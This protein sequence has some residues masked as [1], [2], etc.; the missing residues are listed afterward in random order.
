MPTEFTEKVFALVDAGDA[1]GF[2]RLFASQ[3]WIR[4]ANGE[5]MA[6]PDAVEA[7][8]KGFFTTIKGLR[9]TVLRE[10]ADGSDTVTEL[11]VEYDRLDGQTVTIPVVTAWSLDDSG[12]FDSYRVY[13]DLSPVYA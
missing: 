2:S 12:L 9:H 8:V 13:F 6:G 11:S 4:F 10:W 5:P 3:G 7:G 1:T